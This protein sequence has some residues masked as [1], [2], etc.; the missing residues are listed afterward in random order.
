[1]ERD[2]KTPARAP[3]APDREE[4]DDSWFK[5]KKP[6]TVPPSRPTEPDPIGDPVADDWFVP[7]P[8]T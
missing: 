2:G 1:M 4:L 6:D 5:W 8:G 3:G 7:L